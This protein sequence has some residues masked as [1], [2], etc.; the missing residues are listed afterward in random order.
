[1]VS[2]VEGIWLARAIKRVPEEERWT[3]DTVNW[4]MWAP[5]HRYKGDESEDGEVPEGVPME[6]RKEGTTSLEEKKVFLT[7]RLLPPKDF[8]ITK[9][10]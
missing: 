10:M 1:M 3:E 6:E 9:K 8:M 2:T 4:V 7:T 5:W